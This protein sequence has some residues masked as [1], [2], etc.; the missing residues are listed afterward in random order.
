M[1][2]IVASKLTGAVSLAPL[3]MRLESYSRPVSPAPLRFAKPIAV[4]ASPLRSTVK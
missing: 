2:A 1:S 4:I 3:R